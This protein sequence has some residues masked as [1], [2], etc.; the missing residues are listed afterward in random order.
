MNLYDELALLFCDEDHDGTISG[1]EKLRLEYLR[2]LIEQDA[3]EVAAAGIDDADR[4]STLGIAL[5]IDENRKRQDK[6]RAR[7]AEL[8]GID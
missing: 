2:S 7:L 4:A 1:E 8:L 6:N 5:M 3:D